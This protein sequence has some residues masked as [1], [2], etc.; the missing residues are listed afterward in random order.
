[1]I[2]VAERENLGRSSSNAPKRP[3]LTVKARAEVPAFIT[4]SSFARDRARPR[5][6]SRNINHAELEPMIIGRNFDQDQRHQQLHRH[7]VG[8]GR[9]RQDGVG[10][11]LGR[12]P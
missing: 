5:H 10:D 12:R 9:S 4:L 6:H 8:R 11:P 2:Y 1:M 3:L 7:L